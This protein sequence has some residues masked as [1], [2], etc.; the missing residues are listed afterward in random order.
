MLLKF[1]AVYFAIFGSSTAISYVG[2]VLIES[3]ASEKSF[4][5]FPK[6]FSFGASTAAYQV[7]I[8]LF[9]ETM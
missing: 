4:N 9:S 3:E 8:V 2:P 5:A 1:I 6:D 7:L